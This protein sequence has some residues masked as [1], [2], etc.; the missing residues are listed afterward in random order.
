M[1]GEEIIPHDIIIMDAKQVMNECG[2]K[3]GA[4]LP[5]KAMEQAGTTAARQGCEIGAIDFNQ[6]RAEWHCLVKLCHPRMGIGRRHYR[7]RSFEMGRMTACGFAVGEQYLCRKAKWT[8]AREAR[9][10]LI[11]AQIDDGCKPECGDLIK[12][13]LRRLSM[14]ARTPEQTGA[15]LAAACNSIA[16]IIA[17][18]VNAIKGEN[19]AVHACNLLSSLPLP[20]L[21]ACVNDR[22]MTEDWTGWIG[23]E[24]VQHDI[25]TP[26]LLAR[27]R[28]TFDSDASADVAPQ[29]LH[30]C[31]C[32][33]DVAT[34]GLGPDGHPHKGGFLPPV[35]LPRRMWASSDIAFHAPISVGAAITRISRIADI[36]R[37]QGGSGNLVFVTVAHET[38]ADGA[39]AVSETQTIVY[40]APATEPIA[41]PSAAA[42][43]PDLSGWQWQR[44]LAPQEALLFRY[45]ALTFNSHRIHYD[46]PYA[47]GEE[48]YPALVVHGPLS[49]T[50][51]LDLAAREL[52]PNQLSHF[53][54]RGQAPAFAGEMLNFV[55]READDGFTMAVIGSDGRIVMS[56]NGRK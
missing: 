36:V 5:R 46:L 37:K 39:F 19:P 22:R 7:L 29:G 11:A 27:F 42:T 25:L 17:E 20:A 15:Q 12:V 24:T 50:L 41:A 49:A 31:L 4:V 56:A 18:V 40:R 8:R 38:R 44:S 13:S 48:G 53:A 9:P 10:L 33:P 23:R 1:I 34:A 32:T 28:A 47:Q 26:A 55:G 21:C 30:W 6:Q 52:G 35:P 43:A 16:A 54:F 51:L 3:A 2:G 14:L 45:S